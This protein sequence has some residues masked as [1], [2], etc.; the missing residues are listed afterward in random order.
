MKILF[1]IGSFHP[2]KAGGPSKT[3]YWHVSALASKETESFVIATSTGIDSTHQIKLNTWLQQPYGKVMFCSR[4]IHYMPFK[5]LW[6]SIRLLPKVDIVHL[7]GITYP[8]SIIIALFSI[9]LR[10]PIVWSVR[11]GLEEDAIKHSNV[12]VKN[13]TNKIISIV[14]GKNVWFHATSNNEESQIKKHLQTKNEILQISNYFPIQLPLAKSKKKYILFLGRIDAIKGLEL[15][16]EAISLSKLMVNKEFK[17]KLAGNH[18]NEYGLLL[19]EQCDRLGIS[20]QVEFLGRVDGKEKQILL[21]EA[22]SLILP[23][24]S[25]NFGNVIVEALAEGT[26]VIT[27]KGTPWEE[28]EREG[29][30]FWVNNDPKTLGKTI[31]KLLLLTAQ[32]HELMCEKA[33]AFSKKFNISLNINNWVDTYK[34]ILNSKK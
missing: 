6:N 18:Q 16:I 29:G 3:M 12:R 10:K 30:G 19:Q 8:P 28:L 21:S 27:S 17:L 7:T 14:A 22:Y 26:P 34:K 32:E 2:A 20:D 11:G 33:L 31:D 4:L 15:L 23:S 5:L 24:H 9:F 25:E 1:P 13:L